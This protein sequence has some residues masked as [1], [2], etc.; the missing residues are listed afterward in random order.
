[1]K[2][3]PESWKRDFIIREQNS[4]RKEKTREPLKVIR[5]EQEKDIKDNLKVRRK[6]ASE[7]RIKCIR[8]LEEIL[9]MR[10]ECIYDS[11]GTAH[12]SLAFTIPFQK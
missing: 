9:L 4:I 1:M 3:K 8:E 10:T 2:G 6:T 5:K 7:E 12:N 11:S